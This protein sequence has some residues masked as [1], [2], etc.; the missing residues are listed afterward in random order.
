MYGG[1]WSKTGITTIFPS[2]HHIENIS[3]KLI[4]LTIELKRTPKIFRQ[5]LF[6]LHP[7]G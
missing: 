2:T 5:C 1:P 4:Y 7:S 6:N 3:Y